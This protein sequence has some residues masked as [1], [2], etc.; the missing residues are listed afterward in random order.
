MQRGV[1]GFRQRHIRGKV[2]IAGLS[3][4]QRTT[5]S[6][7]EK[8]ITIVSSDIRLQILNIFMKS[9]CEYIW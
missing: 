9:I 1:I 5:F 3:T 2:F 6:G 4:V 7:V 8:E